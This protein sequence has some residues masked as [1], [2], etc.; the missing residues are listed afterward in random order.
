MSRIDAAFSTLRRNGEKG[1]VA[2]LTAGYP[3]L[4]LLPDLVMALADSGVD[5]LELGIPFSDPLADGPT[6][7]AASEKA[8]AQGVTPRGVLRAVENLRRR[9][10]ILPIALMTYV[11]PVLQYGIKRFCRES[12]L[13]GADGFIVPDLPPEEAEELVEAARPL[14][15]N[16]IFLAAP[17]SP[18]ERLRRILRVSTGFVYYVSLTGV[19]GARASLPAQVVQEVRAIQRMTPLPVC[20]GFGVSA[21]RQVRELLRAADG[22]IVGSALLEEIGKAPSN[23]AGRLRAFVRAL[24]EACH[25]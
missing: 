14:G 22:V 4:K 19:T 1:L 20:V 6:I 8:L 24:K 11:N 3:S 2:Y 25:G 21:P 13:S 12:L 16:T 18:S 9:Q 17:T 5:V 15:L 10:V 23:P 7:Q